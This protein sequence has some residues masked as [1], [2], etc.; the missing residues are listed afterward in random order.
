MNNIDELKN[1]VDELAKAKKAVLSTLE[2]IDVL[3]DMHGLSYWAER[4]EILR[5]EIKEML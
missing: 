5:K 2:N 3:V 1:K 4:V